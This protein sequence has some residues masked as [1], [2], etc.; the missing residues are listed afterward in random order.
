[1]PIDRR[2]RL[3]SLEA[4]LV[5]PPRAKIIRFIVEPS[6][7]G[8]R[9]ISARSIDGHVIPK[10]PRESDEAFRIR[11]AHELGVAA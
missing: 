7:G 2:Q 10:R 11:A 3:A 6:P 5:L 1:M 4:R 8:P 9:T